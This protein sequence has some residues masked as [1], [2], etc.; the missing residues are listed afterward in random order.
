MNP[1]TIPNNLPQNIIAISAE[2]LAQITSLQVAAKSITAIA[3]RAQ[4]DAANEVVRG[5]NKLAKAI[6]AEHKKF[7]APILDLGRALDDA[8]GEAIAPLAGIKVDL[9]RMILAYQEAEN[10]RLAYQHRKAQEAARIAAEE[11]KRKADE[12]AAELAACNS[13]MSADD[14]PPP[15]QVQVVHVPVIMPPGKPKLIKSSAVTERTIKDLEIY[16]QTL[17]P[18]TLAGA[19]L[20]VPDSKVIK[21]LLENG[22]QIPGCRLQER[23][24]VA[25]K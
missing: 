24:I 10:A 21:K 4:F 17:I 2:M 13:S 25:A 6:E 5:A 7:K 3:D 18:H 16:D 19:V 8:A 11:A 9:G 14:T 12:A 15:D 1:V 20:L 22:V 23:T